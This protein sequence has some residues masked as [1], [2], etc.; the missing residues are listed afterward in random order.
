MAPHRI[1]HERRLT[2]YQE[3][4]AQAAAG[5]DAHQ[6]AAP[7]F[8]TRHEEPLLAWMPDIRP[9][10][11]PRESLR[12]M[13]KVGRPVGPTH[14]LAAELCCAYFFLRVKLLV[15]VAPFVIFTVVTVGW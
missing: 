11:P 14:P 3:S 8:G 6:Q 10:S 5:L 1:G 7:A 9:P 12:P 13:R 2:E 15:T 4:A